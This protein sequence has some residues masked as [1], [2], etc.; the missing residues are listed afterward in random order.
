MRARREKEKLSYA[1]PAG[2]SLREEIYR[3][4]ANSSCDRK[5]S[6]GETEGQVCSFFTQE[7]NP[8]AYWACD[9]QVV[10]VAET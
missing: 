10:H 5:K 7:V 6:P 4:T 9:E 3:E 1:A 8:K 2:P